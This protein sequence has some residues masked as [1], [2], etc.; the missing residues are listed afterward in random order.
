MPMPEDLPA[1]IEFMTYIMEVRERTDFDD[2]FIPMRRIGK[3][4]I[5][6]ILF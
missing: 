3:T 1:L 2:M 4:E 5:F 6:S